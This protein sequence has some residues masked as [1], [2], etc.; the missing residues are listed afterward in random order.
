MKKQNLISESGTKSPGGRF[1]ES[2]LRIKRQEVNGRDVIPGFLDLPSGTLEPDD[3]ERYLKILALF[4][5]HILIPDGWLHCMGPLSEH[6]RAQF[7]AAKEHLG[8]KH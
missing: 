1:P 2:G 4:S 8:G 6:L 5:D 3:L 7:R